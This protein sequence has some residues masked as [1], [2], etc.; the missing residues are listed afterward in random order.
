MTNERETYAEAI[1]LHTNR[2]K[3]YADVTKTQRKIT[4]DLRWLIN[5]K[6][7]KEIQ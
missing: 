7:N 3:T 5:Q 4:G 1:K 2:Q 6:N